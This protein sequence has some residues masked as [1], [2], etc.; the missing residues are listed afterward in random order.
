M[1]SQVLTFYRLSCLYVIEWIANLTWEPAVRIIK[2]VTGADGGG[3]FTSERAFSSELRRQEHTV[4]GF[5]VGDGPSVPF[6]EGVFSHVISLDTDFPRFDGSFSKKLVRFPQALLKSR[7]LAREACLKLEA[8]TS[9]T[10]IAIRKPILLPLAGELANRLGVPVLWHI[11]ETLSRFPKRPIFKQFCRTYH[12]VPIGNSHYTNEQMGFINAPVVFPTYDPGSLFSDGGCLRSELSI[13]VGTPVFG[14]A[15]RLTYEKGPDLVVRAFL[16]S[17]AFRDGA[18]LLL[19]GGPLEGRLGEELRSVVNK[20]GNGQVHLLGFLRDISSFYRT[21]DVAVNGRRD[22]EPFGIS[23]IEALASGKPVIAYKLGA[24]AETID[25]G[26]TGWHVME[27]TVAGYLEGFDRA[28]AARDRWV[29]MGQCGVKSASAFNVETQ[30]SRY[31]EY[32][33]E[34]LD[35]RLAPG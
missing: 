24:P 30:V 31:V 23:I 9:E 19:A 29:A 15:A 6:Y 13:P 8:D 7:A 3:V 33:R 21:I 2:I 18:H 17:E 34:V 28:Y 22:A 20:H 12:V 14:S 5:I 32:A 10:I 25:D 35:G 27:P 1:T 16:Q 4:D 11:P 26:V